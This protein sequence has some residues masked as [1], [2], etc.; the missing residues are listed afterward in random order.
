MTKKLNLTKTLTL[1]LTLTLKSPLILTQKKKKQMNEK[2]T[3]R[4]FDKW[5]Q[6][7][8]RCGRDKSKRDG[9]AKWR[10]GAV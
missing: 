9:A 4:Q 10:Q 2:I 8:L 6:V 1:Q 3:P 7:Y 5:K